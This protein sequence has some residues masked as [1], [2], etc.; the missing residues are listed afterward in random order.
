MAGQSAGVIHY[1]IDVETASVLRGQQAVND[2]LDKA[3]AGFTKTDR[4]AAGLSTTLDKAGK[5]ANSANKGIRDMDSASGALLTRL[6][7]LSAAIA[8]LFTLQALK[9]FQQAAEQTNL[10][11]SRITRL[12]GSAEAGRVTYQSLLNIANQTGSQLPATVKLWESLQQ[13]LTSLGATQPQILNLV[14]TLQKIGAIGGSSAEEIANSLYQFGQSVTSGKLQAEE[15]NSIIDQMPELARQI[16]KGLG[17]S[18]DEFIFKVKNGGVD[19]TD[20]L[21]AIQRQTEIVNTEFSKIPRTSEQA[22][23]AIKNSFNDALATLDNLL[24]AS[25]KIVAV[26]DYINFGL[27]SAKGNLSPQEE[28]NGLLEDRADLQRRLAALNDQWFPDQDKIRSLNSMLSQTN[29]RIQDLQRFSAP[30]GAPANAAI[31]PTTRKTS[32]ED[33]KVLEALKDQAELAKVAGEARARLAAEQKLSATASDE[34]KKAAGDLAVQIYQLTEAK[35]ADKKATSESAS[36]A[37]SA[38]KQNEKTLKDLKDSISEVGLTGDALAR[39][40]A[41]NSLNKYATPEQIKQLEDL[42]VEL[43]RNEGLVDNIELI[44]SLTKELSLASKQ[45]LALAQAQELLKLNKYATPDQVQQVKALTA[46]IY[47]QEQVKA[48][49]TLL[50]QVDP[51]AGAQQNF[52]T[53]L[54][55]LQKLNDAKLLSDMRYI[56]LK[57]QAE[58]G[59]QERMRALEEERFRSQSVANDLLIGSINKFGDASTNAITGLLSGTYKAQDGIRV[60][61]QGILQEGVSALVQLGLQQVKNLV[62]GQT[63]QAAATASGLAQAAVLSSAYAAP[64]ALASLASFG[65]NAAPA[66]AALAS[67]VAFAK[68]LGV[69]GGRQ[70]G[71]PVDGNSMYRVNE[72]GAPEVFNAANGQQFMIPNQNGKVVSNKDATAGEGQGGGSVQVNIYNDPSKA[73]TVNETRGENGERMVDIFVA[74]IMGDGKMSRAIQNTYGVRRVGQ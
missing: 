42:N 7:P 69:A 44:E 56:E 52:Q 3:Q 33:K 59:Y 45:G 2:A 37:K 70:Y 32:P 55:N 17:M 67:T 43:K 6:N 51:I 27:K 26:L 60:L 11:A 13:S 12:A 1:S 23:N 35:K 50:G 66:N 68:T 14:G 46:A 22:G 20:A 58:K 64:A 71:G 47:Q 25:Q 10:L 16:A 53:E 54:D 63:G 5:S 18:M 9:G 62:I 8:G 49:K 24:G 73:G 15:F 74:D 39:V 30:T 31:T 41:K 28:L 29:A 34:E 40:A 19:A 72:N 21:N 61:A 65:A 57:E 48:N 4:A 36:E 38:A